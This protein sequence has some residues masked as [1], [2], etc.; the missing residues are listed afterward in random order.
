[1]PAP[2]ASAEEQQSGEDELIDARDAQQKEESR[3]WETLG[4]GA[5]EEATEKEEGT[6]MDMEIGGKTVEAGGAEPALEE[7]EKSRAP[8]TPPGFRPLELTELLGGAKGGEKKSRNR[9]Q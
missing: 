2:S 8:T 1:M 6:P 3:K 4:E 5:E 9:V 7:R